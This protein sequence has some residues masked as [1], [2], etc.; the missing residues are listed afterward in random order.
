MAYDDILKE[1]KEK[2]EKALKH[3]HDL[4]RGV[5]TGRASTALVENLRVEYY[6]TPTPLNQLA[7]ISVPEPRTVAIKPFDAGVINDL[8][9]AVQK[10]DLGIT[11]QSDGKVVRLSIPP[12]SGE[13]RTKLAAKV[14]ELCEEGRVAMRNGRR[15]MNKLADQLSKSGELTEDENKKLH[16]KIQ[17]ILKD[18]E[19]KIDQTYEQKTAEVMEV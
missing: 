12:L 9:K 6:G 1:T 10:S 18:Y 8:M 3:L 4:L 13:Q 11:P 15:E 16:D 2:M 14:K 17:D 7:S 5:R 19:K